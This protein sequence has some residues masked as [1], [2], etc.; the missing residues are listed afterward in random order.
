[1]TEISKTRRKFLKKWV[2]R[3]KLKKVKTCALGKNCES[4][5]LEINKLRSWGGKGDCRL[6]ISIGYCVCLL[7][8]IWYW[9]EILLSPQSHQP[10]PGHPL[11]PV[12]GTL[13]SLLERT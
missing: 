7:V 4:G 13:S 1:M 5:K 11:H 12:C 3:G 2:K 8:K 9:K 6:N 10:R